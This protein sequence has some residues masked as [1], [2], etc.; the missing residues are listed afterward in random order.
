[1]EVQDRLAALS[2]ITD[3]VLQ[4]YFSK[5]LKKLITV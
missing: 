5:L 3:L 1:M 2:R 4:N